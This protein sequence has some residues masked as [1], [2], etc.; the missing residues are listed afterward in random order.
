MA[1]EREG[2]KSNP[3]D[4]G[5]RFTS[6][7]IPQGATIHSAYV[8]GYASDT[9][10]GATATAV[11]RGED[12]DTANAFST[13]TN[14]IARIKTSASV[15]WASIAA[16]TFGTAYNTPS[17]TTIIQ[18]IVNRA[19]WASGNAIVIFVEN[20][21]SSSGAYREWAAYDHLT[22][23]APQLVVTFS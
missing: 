5:V 13:Y 10:S 1:I 18:E 8:R 12:A 20:N 2:G 22:L 19:S 11:I 17:L 6:L 23:A 14:F 9:V 3:C 16:W 21:G 4:L 7:L 15:A